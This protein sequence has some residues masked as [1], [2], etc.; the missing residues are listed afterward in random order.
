LNETLVTLVAEPGVLSGVMTFMY[1][2]M[3]LPH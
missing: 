1:S 3:V 2:L